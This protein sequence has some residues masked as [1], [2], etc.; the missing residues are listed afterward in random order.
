VPIGQ[1]RDIGGLTLL[2]RRT[3]EAEVVGQTIK[4]ALFDLDPT[5]RYVSIRSL[6]ERIDPQVR[7]W[8]LGASLFTAFGAL[9]FL[10]AA[11]GLYSVVTY[12]TEQRTQELGIRLALGAQRRDVLRLVLRSGLTMAAAGIGVGVL[13]ALA[14]GPEIEPLLFGT[15]ARSPVVFAVVT[16]VL[17]IAALAASFIPARRATRVD[18]VL[19]LRS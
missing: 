14:A 15:S 12:V 4:S 9:A 7:P 6:Q 16:A 19:A 3:E 13:L 1:Q 18:P 11:L 17:L 5:L 10:I 8:R 2:V